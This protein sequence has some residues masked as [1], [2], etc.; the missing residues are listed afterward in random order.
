MRR[1]VTLGIAVG[2]IAAVGLVGAKTLVVV[3]EPPP[4]AP[5]AGA[6]PV[7]RFWSPVTGAHFYTIS[8]REKDKLIEKYADV[9]T[10]EGPA[11]Y[12]WPAPPEPNG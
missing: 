5:P 3:A 1:I 7:Y 8:E 11:F 9:W 2:F 4:P 12:A 6:R 10:F